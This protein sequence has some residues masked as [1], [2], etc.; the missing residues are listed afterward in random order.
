[1][2]GYSDRQRNIF[3]FSK[4]IGEGVKINLFKI[5]IVQSSDLDPPPANRLA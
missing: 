1:M 2:V 5:I 4:E 3:L